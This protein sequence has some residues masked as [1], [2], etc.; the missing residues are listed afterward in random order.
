MKEPQ[1]VGRARWCDVADIVKLVADALFHSATGAWLVPDERRRRDV[2]SAVTRVW[3][4]H[5]LFFGE[6]YVLDDHSAAAVWFHRYGPIPPPA[7]Y[8][9][10]LAVACGD[11]IDRFLCLDEVLS[12]H[13]PT[14]PHNHLAF[15]AVPPDPRRIDRAAALLATSHA[16]I[17]HADHPA[18]AEA[19]SIAE[20]DLYARHGYD[21]HPPFTLPDGTTAYPMWR[22]REGAAPS[23]GHPTS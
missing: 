15:F 5:A 10:R 21:A 9:S 11:H 4:E 1:W 18:Y 20:R 3:T 17:D 8:G 23:T 7:G 2:L 6:A 13:R 12:T 19:T 14:G 16:S 22:T